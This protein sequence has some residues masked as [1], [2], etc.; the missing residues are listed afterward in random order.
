[1]HLTSEVEAQ[2]LCVFLSVYGDWRTPTLPCRYVDCEQESGS[3]LING[4][5]SSSIVADTHLEN[6]HLK[7]VF[8]PRSTQLGDEYIPL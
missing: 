2:L 6:N 8:I 5:Y 3:H 1:M 7:C 4:V